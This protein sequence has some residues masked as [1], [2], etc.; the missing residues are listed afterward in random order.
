[1]RIDPFQLFDLQLVDLTYLNRYFVNVLLG[2]ERGDSGL[3]DE[4][5][6]RLFAALM[7]LPEVANHFAKA[8]PTFRAG[9]AHAQA[10]P[11]ELSS[12]ELRSTQEAILKRCAWNV[13]MAK[14]PAIWDA[15]PWSYWDPNE[16]HSRVDVRDRVVLD[17]GAGTG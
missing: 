13:G 15:L 16:I 8:S 4:F 1:M 14:S 2:P 11:L 12:D 17:I 7:P 5:G 6:E 9:L 10:Q 3:L